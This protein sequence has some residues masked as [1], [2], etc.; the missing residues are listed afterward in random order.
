MARTMMIL[1]AAY[2]AAVPV[3]GQSQPN[4]DSLTYY[5]K[6]FDDTPVSA[7]DGRLLTSRGATV[8]QA[9]LAALN[10]VNARWEPVHTIPVERLREFRERGSIGRERPLPDL[11]VEFLASIPADSVSTAVF[12]AALD[13]NPLVEH[14]HEQTPPIPAVPPDFQSNQGYLVA[15]QDG[16]GATALWA[17]PGATGVWVK[18]AVVEFCFNA[19]HLDLPS[20]AIYGSPQYCSNHE[21]QHG[22][23]TMGVIASLAN[24]WGTTG[25]AHGAEFIFSSIYTSTGTHNTAGAVTTAANQLGAGDVML[26][27][28]QTGTYLPVEWS[29]AEYNAIKTVVAN[30]ISVVIAAGNGNTQLDPNIPGSNNHYPFKQANSSGAIYVGA[31]APPR[32]HQQPAR[33]RLS[34]SN[35]GERIDLQAWGES[36]FTTGWYGTDY[37]AEGPNL[38]YSGEYAGTSSASP[39][40]TGAVAV[41]QSAHV[42]TYGI[43]AGPSHLRN[44]LVQTG[45]AQ[46]MSVNGKIGPQPSLPGAYYYITTAAPNISVQDNMC[47]GQ[48]SASWSSVSSAI[49]YQL[50]ALTDWGFEYDAYNGG[51]TSTPLQVSETTW[52]RVRGCNGSPGSGA[53]CSPWSYYA[54]PLQY[55]PICY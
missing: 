1:L 4:I 17:S 49:T 42:L 25:I 55:H 14:F 34:F 10:E 52:Y 28:L 32:H 30:G 27:N 48:G 15:P 41:L 9:D 40:V 12:Q 54:G 51:G 8:N 2:I 45:V 5:V 20:I 38:Y 47:F 6:L 23:A 39:M 13:R 21:Q 31:G 50:R 19:N 37:W 29:L 26:V 36:V 46:D 53:G 43:K 18:V 44:A 11:T 35:H 16:I 7:A 24:G 3:S 33:S 22:T